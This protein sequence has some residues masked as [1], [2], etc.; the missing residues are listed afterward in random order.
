MYVGA[1]ISGPRFLSR[2]HNPVVYQ[3]L[4]FPDLIDNVCPEAR[5]PTLPGEESQDWKGNNSVLV[6]FVKFCRLAGSGS[7]S[8]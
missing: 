3:P 6:C 7:N 5:K 8:E 4:T 2:Y 1:A